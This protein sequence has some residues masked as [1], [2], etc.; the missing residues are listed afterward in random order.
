LH[1]A[2]ALKDKTRIM[3]PDITMGYCNLVLRDAGV[4]TSDPFLRQAKGF[5]FTNPSVDNITG[6]SGSPVFDQ[7]ANVLC[8]MVNRGGMTGNTCTIHYIDIFD[9][10]K[11]L[12]CVSIRAAS[13][14]YTNTKRL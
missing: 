6:I 5:L 4:S 12:E 8:G 2:G 14:S 7:T 1:V 10:T 11:L 9:I 3:P 13:A